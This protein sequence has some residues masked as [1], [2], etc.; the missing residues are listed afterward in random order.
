MS[1][2]ILAMAEADSPSSVLSHVLAPLLNHD[3]ILLAR[4]WVLDD[5]DC[6][7]CRAHRSTPTPIDLH[8]RAHGTRAVTATMVG[9]GLDTSCHLIRLETESAVARI[10]SRGAPTAST[11]GGDLESWGLESDSTIAVDVRGV[12]GYPLHFRG[13]VVGVLVCYLQTPPRPDMLAWL[14]TFAAHAAVAIGNCRALQQI[15]LLH[16]QLEL[17]RDY[18]REEAAEFVPVNGIVGESESL[19][20]VLRQIDLVAPTDATV[21]ILGESGTGKELIARAI[22]QRSPR[23][24]R[25]LVKVNCASI[26]RE[27][28][29]SEFFGHVRGAFT[30]AVS[31]RVGRFQLADRGTLFL[32][33]VGEIPLELQTKLLRVLQEGEFERVGDAS[34]RHVSVRVIAATNRDLRAEVEAGRFRL[35][36]FYRLSV[37][38]MQVP[39]LRERREDIP[40]L[41]IRFLTSASQRFGRPMPR[42]SQREMARLVSY[43]WPGNIRE[44]QHVVE[45][46]LILSGGRGSV[47]FDVAAPEDTTPATDSPLSP[48]RRYRTEAE[49]RNLERNNLLAAL[50]AAR[51]KVAGT[52][53]AATLLGV[54]PN[55][56]ASRLRALGIRR[57][58]T[59][60]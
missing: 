38:P 7:I 21:L 55:T 41:A 48:E 2:I 60:L 37:F 24:G 13:R 36:L 42:V 18:L 54:N 34:A 17:E 16:S 9:S 51:G 58:F 49:W 4:V 8:L 3:E 20:H 27:L 22:Y 45:R 11:V 14:P 50:K 30:G 29:E 23:A 44:L 6:P 1:P 15:Q 28:F 47:H 57:G 46:A 40:A 31:D 26:P 25:A 52:S 19:R 33:E 32:D 53:G 43:E 35:D 10:A 5:R 12:L 56:L 39:P 59:G